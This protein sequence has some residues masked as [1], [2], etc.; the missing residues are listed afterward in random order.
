MDSGE[1]QETRYEIVVSTTG[2]T[3]WVNGDDGLCW[4]R[5]S[6]RWGIDVHRSEAM[7]PADSECLYCTHSKAGVEEWAV[8]RAEVLRHHRVVINT[9]A[10]TFD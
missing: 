7:P 5:F 2:D 3:V 9:D 6:K 10:L 4:A 8:F 1:K